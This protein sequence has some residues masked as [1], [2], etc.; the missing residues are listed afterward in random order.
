MPIRVARMP[1]SPAP[2]SVASRR[3]VVSAA[4]WSSERPLATQN[5]LV[6]GS[7]AEMSSLKSSAK[8]ITAQMPRRLSNA[9][10]GSP[11]ARACRDSR[12]T[13]GRTNDPTASAAVM[14]APAMN[15]DGQPSRA[16]TQTSSALE[17]KLAAR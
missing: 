1:P 6:I 13:S 15:A 17:T 9:S 14:T 5:G 10:I 16:A 3:P 7:I 11:R 12:P 8:M 2:A 4:I